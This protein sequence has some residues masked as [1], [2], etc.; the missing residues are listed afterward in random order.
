MTTTMKM[1]YQCE[2]IIEIN[3]S[4]FDTSLVTDMNNMFAWCTSLYSLD[5]SNIDTSKV[6]NMA[7]MFYRCSALKSLNLS[8]FNTLKVNNTAL[9]FA[10]GAFIYLNLSSFDMTNVKSLT[11]MFYGSIEYINFKIAKIYSNNI[12]NNPEL[13]ISSSSN[14]I[15][16]CENDNDFLMDFFNE[17]ILFIAIITIHINKLNI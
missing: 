1:F 13:L 10:E 12:E 15:I 16:A 2:Q 3:L 7:F 14:S 4:K 11:R 5:L 17:K 8:N 9:M 6:I